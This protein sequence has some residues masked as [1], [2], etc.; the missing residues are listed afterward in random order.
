M[1]Y[2]SLSY[3]A[4]LTLL[5]GC[6]GNKGADHQTGELIT[7]DVTAD[8][9]EKELILQDFMD[10]EY[11]PL[12]NSD[13][14]IT[15]GVVKAVGKEHILAKNWKNDGDIFVFDRK[16]GNG[17]RKIN[18]KGGS[19]EEY[20]GITDIILDE[21]KNEMFIVN[22]TARVIVAYDLMG[23]YK[24]K[25]QFADSCYYENVSNYDQD[26]LIA[27]KSY[28]PEKETKQSA[29]VCI[30]KKDGSVAREF[31]IET[32]KTASP[33]FIKGDLTVMPGFDLIMPAT[34]GWLLTRCSS[35]SIYSADSNGNLHAAIKR[36]PSIH[37]MDPEVFL[38]PILDSDRYLLLQTL[39]KEVDLT[40]FKGFPSTFLVYDRDE[41]N[42]S[43]C[44]VYNS[45][46]VNKQEVN[47]WWSPINPRSQEI[48]FCQKL[49]A[50]DLVEAYEKGEL[51][52]RL[53]EIAATL[54]EDSNP[55]IMLLKSKQ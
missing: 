43:K 29:H 12:D 37:E 55:V 21:D 45:D 27:Y 33:V 22:N 4:A 31:T 42:V 25:F 34:T 52:G 36:T 14:Y 46:Y 50:L 18:R 5:V 41:K 1:K 26:H 47:F 54:N 2:T 9:P 30:S 35:D 23:N 11:I 13:E 20:T 39:L 19:G 49:E 40:T 3:I 51:K 16:T 24:R 15:Q 48:A 53:K 17:I 44:T 10:V 28:P 32:T 8:Y 6:T 7:I 38:F